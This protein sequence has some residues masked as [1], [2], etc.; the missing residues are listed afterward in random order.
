MQ[1]VSLVRVGVSQGILD[2]DVEKIN[3]LT[4]SL[5]PAT[6]NARKNENLPASKRDAVRAQEI[7]EAL[8]G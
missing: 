3:E 7:R 8:G 1:L 4:V 5:Q 6:I 2:V